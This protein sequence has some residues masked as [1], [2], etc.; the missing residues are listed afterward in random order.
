MNKPP[1]E[2]NSAHSDQDGHCRGGI[3]D[4]KREGGWPAVIP[5]EGEEHDADDEHVIQEI[6]QAVL[7]DETQGFPIPHDI[8]H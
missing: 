8:E 4:D 5:D 2:G 1:E 6:E 3:E 7:A